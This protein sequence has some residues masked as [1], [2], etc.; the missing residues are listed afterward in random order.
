MDPI[1]D[2][3]D[4]ELWVKRA[5]LRE[6][7]GHAIRFH[8]AAAEVRLW[9][10]GRALT[11][12]FATHWQAD[13]RRPFVIVESGARCCRCQFFCKP[14]E[15]MDAGTAVCDN[16]VEC[17]NLLVKAGLD[18]VDPQRGDLPGPWH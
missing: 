13:D 4:T 18:H 17:A 12:S 16:L 9:P 15:Q 1:P 11:P 14:Y 8:M 7:Y 10:F 6:R 3:D 5:G 2:I